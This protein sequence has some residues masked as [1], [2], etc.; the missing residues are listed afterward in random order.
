MAS[1]KATCVL[2]SFLWGTTRDTSRVGQF[3]EEEIIALLVGSNNV[4]Q[5]VVQV[6]ETLGTYFTV[7]GAIPWQDYVP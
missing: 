3:E 6:R 4:A 1:V 7:Q 2:H 5:E